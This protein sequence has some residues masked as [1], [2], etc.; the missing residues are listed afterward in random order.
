MP[1]PIPA[2][3]GGVPVDLADPCALYAALYTVKMKRLA[4]EGVEET[5]IRSPVTHRRLKLSSVNMSLLEAELTKLSEAC[6]AINSPCVR[7]TRFAK[8]IRFV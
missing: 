7:R 3:I 5:E 6:T 2:L 8:R 4:G 1:E